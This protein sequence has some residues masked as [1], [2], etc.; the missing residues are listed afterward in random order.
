[1]GALMDAKQAIAQTSSACVN[2][3]TPASG[4]SRGFG[5]PYDVFSPTKPLT[6][7]GTCVGD[8][9]A[10]RAGGGSSSELIYPSGYYYANGWKQMSFTGTSKNGVWYAGNASA[11]VPMSGDETYV[12][13]YMCKLSGG[14][15]CG[16]AD[17]ACTTPSWQVQRIVKSSGMEQPNAPSRDDSDPWLMGYYVGYQSRDYR[18]R[19]IDFDHLTHIAA[20]TVRIDG[21]GNV[22]P[23]FDLTNGDGEELGEDIAR[24]AKREGVKSL[25]WVGG[26]GAESAWRDATDSSRDRERL[27]DNLIETMEDLGYDGID[28]N[29]EPLSGRDAGNLS[30]LLKELRNRKPNM[31]ITLP[32]NWVHMNLNDSDDFEFLAD[33]AP[34]VDR[35]FIMS[36]SMGS[37]WSGWKSWHNSPLY[38]ETSLTPSSIDSSVE[39][40][41][42]AGVPRK[43]LGIGA[44]FYGRC[45]QEP[46]EG[47][48]ESIPSGYGNAK[49]ISMSYNT[50]MEDYYDRDAYEYD[51]DADAAY[52]T[53]DEPEGDHDCTFISYDDER[54][55]RAKGEYIQDNRLGGM[56]LWTL[57]MGHVDEASSSK[58]QALLKAAYEA[59]V[60]D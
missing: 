40:Y 8:S 36:Y 38:G 58:Q 6:L 11:V 18:P 53:F 4:P 57:R 45:W 13:A 9:I 56:I 51:D 10:V 27:A 31:L 14:W 29:W 7:T 20:G 42:D 59:V 44:A 21:N 15:K 60:E 12:A 28:V 48:G 23:D 47:P 55:L 30:A 39:T 17:A 46:I 50:I 54:S 24:R 5:A 16:C 25:L 2:A 32:V 26:P 3:I 1:M 34:Y 35:F 37:A 22:Y 41:L 49:I 43:K 19:D 33:V 52:L